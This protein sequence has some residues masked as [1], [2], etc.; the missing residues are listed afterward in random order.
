MKV[1]YIAGTPEKRDSLLEIAEVTELALLLREPHEFVPLPDTPVNLLRGMIN[2]FRPD[3]LH[4]AAHGESSA[5]Q[6]RDFDGSAK[7]VTAD[8]LQRYL[9]Q[10]EPVALVYLNA[11]NSA[12]LA[13]SLAETSEQAYQTAL[14]ICPG[15]T[16]AITGL[17]RVLAQQGQLDQ[18][19]QALD[20]FLQNNP[21]QSQTVNNLRQGLRGNH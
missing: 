1:L 10:E 18:A 7:P 4:L 13:K 11:C 16:E 12:E 6:L 5:I 9:V 2:R 15:S 3:V 21:N 19:G 8:T 17:T 14:N 20:T